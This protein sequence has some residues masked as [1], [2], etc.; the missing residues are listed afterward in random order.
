MIDLTSATWKEI[1]DYIDVRTAKLSKELLGQPVKHTAEDDAER[2]ARL[3]ELGA[4]VTKF[5]KPEPEK[6]DE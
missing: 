6:T 1:A 3:F 4:L 2:R 5:T